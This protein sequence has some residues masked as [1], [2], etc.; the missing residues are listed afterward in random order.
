MVSH[1][2]SKFD[3]AVFEGLLGH[4]MALT[5]AFDFDFLRRVRLKKIRQVPGIAPP[6]IK[7]VIAHLSCLEVTDGG[8][9]PAGEIDAESRGFAAEEAKRP[10]SGFRQVEPFARG[11]GRHGVADFGLDF[12]NV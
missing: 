11:T 2:N 3:G 7:M 10:V 1:M 9:T 12:D 8:K 6:A 5:P 4:A